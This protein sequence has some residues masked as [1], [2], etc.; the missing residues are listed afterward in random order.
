LKIESKQRAL[1]L[2]DRQLAFLSLLYLHSVILPSSLT[3]A[4][5]S[6]EAVF[7]V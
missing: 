3:P 4:E 1:F 5:V 2:L 7:G 6:D